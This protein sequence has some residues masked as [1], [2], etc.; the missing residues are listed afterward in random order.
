MATKPRKHSEILWIGLGEASRSLG[1]NESTLRRWSDAGLVQTFRT[2]GGHRRF[3]ASD[4][5]RL[6]NE[7]ETESQKF[8]TKKID[9]E[10]MRRI[11]SGLIDDA[12]KTQTWMSQIP[13]SAR[14]EMADLG[15]ETVLLIE[16]YLST[17]KSESATLAT[18][19][20]PLPIFAEE[21]MMP[22][23]HTLKNTHCPPTLR[24]DYGNAYPFSKIGY[25]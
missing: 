12:N 1:V 10:A 5:R 9:I 17:A 8:I 23:E 15:R 6:V 22:F 13:T 3:S 2:P 11:R 19:Y 25:Y 20:S 4:L 7:T 21:W 24:A 18:P 16:R 14:A